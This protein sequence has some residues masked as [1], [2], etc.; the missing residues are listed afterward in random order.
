MKMSSNLRLLLMVEDG[1]RD[2]VEVAR[3]SWFDQDGALGSLT[4]AEYGGGSSMTVD[5]VLGVGDMLRMLV[6]SESES[7]SL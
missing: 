6:L 2:S 1:G 3:G 7:P 5:M 4:T